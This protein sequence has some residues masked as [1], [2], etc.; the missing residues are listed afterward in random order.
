MI[1][2]GRRVPGRDSMIVSC[3]SMGLIDQAADTTS[4]TAKMPRS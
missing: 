2:P 1:G 4:R 3:L